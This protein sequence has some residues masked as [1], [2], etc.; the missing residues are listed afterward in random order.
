M[1]LRIGVIGVGA[2][3]SAHCRTIAGEVAGAELA[4]VADADAAR[5]AAL[6]EELGA[7]AFEDPLELVRDGDVDAVVV[8]SS[9]DTH[10]GFVLA[11]LQASKPVLCEKPLAPTAEASL[12]VVEAEAALGR[13]LVQVA[14][15]RRYDLGYRAVKEGLD[16]GAVG[17]PLL[18][19]CAH[20]NAGVPPSYTSEM[21]FTSSASHEV[22]VMRWLLG[23][24]LVAARVLSPR[25]TR[26]AREGLRDPQLVVLEADDGVLIDV[27]VF[28]N[29]QYGYDI[30]CE[31][32]GETGILT[33]PAPVGP[34][35]ADYRARFAPAYRDQLRH[36]VGAVSAGG[37][38]AGPSAWD[39]Y[40]AAAVV[41]ACV[42]SLH[43]GGREE[44]RV[45]E[46]PE[47]Y[48]RPQERT[49]AAAT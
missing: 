22:D 3:G 15:M 4:A 26:L 5:A 10:R 2:M 1:S 44:V 27:E 49:V 43:S 39:G 24:E 7:R 14:F 45:A 21:L 33:L 17:A 38:P 48:A 30:R 18:A 35:S 28:A 12:A 8:A 40:A 32:V 9:D 25:S 29:A 20:R 13:R 42:A 36:W 41:D 34:V 31:V 47:L 6:A 37:P 23:R 11:C 16:S 19:H 46:R